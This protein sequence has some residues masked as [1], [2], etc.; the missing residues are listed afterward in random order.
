M[1]SIDKKQQLRDFAAAVAVPVGLTDSEKW[2]VRAGTVI[3]PVRNILVKE[4]L[5]QVNE[6]GIKGIPDKWRKSFDGPTQ[7]WR[8]SHHLVNGLLDEDVDP[9][10]I[11][12]QILFFLEGIAALNNDHYFE[13]I[14]KHIILVDSDVRRT[15]AIDMLEGKKDARRALLL[16][17]LIWSYSETNYFVAHELTCEYHGAY[18]LSD[19]N[20]AVIREF[21]NLRPV[22]LWPNR[23]Y[24]N[25]PDFLRII[26]IHDSSLSISFDVY[27]NLFDEK[28]TMAT[29]LLK[30]TVCTADNRSLSLAEISDLISTFSVK[31]ETFTVEVDAMSK[32]DVSRKFMEV[33]WYRKKSLADYMGISWK[34]AKELYAVL[35]EGLAQGPKKKAGTA[36]SG[37][38]PVDELAKLYDF[39]VYL[40]S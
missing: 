8:M 2:P 11:A 34:P 36:P 16:A 29:S 13:R 20:Y 14:G 9:S 4:L 5:S 23:D 19:G 6:A 22:E 10:E 21:K 24:S 33:F 26:T 35:E 32:M 1:Y 28:G 18:T 39:S 40:N 25:L 3:F 7:L 38:N 15:I 17:G 12:E 31:V 27:N 37:L 30:S